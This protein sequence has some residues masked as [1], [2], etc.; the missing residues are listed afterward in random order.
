MK[1]NSNILFIKNVLIIATGSSSVQLI[2]MIMMPIITRIYLPETL[3][4]VNSFLAYSTILCSVC[5]LCYPAAIA[6]PSKTSDALNIVKISIVISFIFSSIVLLTCFFKIFFS[7]GS[8]DLISSLCLFTIILLS[9]LYQALEQFAIRNGKYKVIAI[10]NLIQSIVSSLIKISVGFFCPLYSILLVVSSISPAISSLYII[11]KNI[12]NLKTLKLSKIKKETLLNFKD[13][14][15]YRAPQSLINS[16]SMGLP[17]LIINYQFGPK[18]AGYYALSVT[19]LSIPVSLVG[20]S[21]SDVF[22]PKFSHL[23]SIKKYD[24]ASKLFDICT[25]IL[26]I[27]SVFPILILFLFGGRLF[28]FVFGNTWYIAGDLAKWVCLHSMAMLISRPALA[29]LPVLKLQRFFLGFEIFSCSFR[30]LSLCIG[31]FYLNDYKISSLLYS[32]SSLII[33]ALL[34]I[35][36]R[37]KIACKIKE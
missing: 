36:C 6:L 11:K 25:L 21:I 31:C 14:P 19:V 28:S 24:V 34:I 26:G 9:G 8:E 15:I 4:E 33:Y 7:L 2:N 23:I 32:V 35:I 3:G 1:K 10:G 5:A 17:V 13:F 30:A 37:R 29:S 22:Y 27:I 16:F 18:I 20:K 12:I